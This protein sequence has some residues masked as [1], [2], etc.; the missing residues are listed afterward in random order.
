M[1]INNQPITKLKENFQVLSQ[2]SLK[3]A[4]DNVYH[5]LANIT[6]NK[7]MLLQECIIH[8]LDKNRWNKALTSHNGFKLCCSG[9]YLQIIPVV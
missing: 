3:P 5:A 2:M 1:N 7:S 6:V 4:L 8:L 9:P